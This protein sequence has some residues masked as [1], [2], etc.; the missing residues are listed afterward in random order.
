MKL[1]LIGKS[2]GEIDGDI[3][4]RVDR[5]V[6]YAYIVVAFRVARHGVVCEH[7]NVCQYRAAGALKQISAEDGLAHS[8]ELR[9]IVTGGD[10]KFPAPLN[11]GDRG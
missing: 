10:D 2:D 1:R 6:G 3:S 5:A 8:T 9:R 7:G 4:E 11:H